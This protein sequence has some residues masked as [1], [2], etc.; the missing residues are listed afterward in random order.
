MQKGTRVRIV[1]G[2]KGK[3]QTGTMFWE[4]PNKWGEGTRIG[5]QGDDGETYWINT[6]NVA[7]LSKDDPDYVPD[8]PGADLSKGMRVRWEKDG[9][10][11]EGVVIWLGENKRG[12]GTRVGVKDDALDDAVFM[13]ARFVTAIDDAPSD[14]DEPMRAMPDAVP[15]GGDDD[16]IPF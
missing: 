12:P 2:R 7:E 8:D 4:G 13:D 14:D 1:K 9:D 11:G 6:D 5:I 15:A 3:G 10:V 16:E